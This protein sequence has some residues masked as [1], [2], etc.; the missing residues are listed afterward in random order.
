MILPYN[1]LG[2]DVLTPPGEDP[3]SGSRL[4]QCMTDASQFKNKGCKSDLYLTTAMRRVSMQSP[5][6]PQDGISDR[7][8]MGIDALQVEAKRG[9]LEA[10]DLAVAKAAHVIGRSFLKVTD[11]CL[12]L[13]KV[14]DQ[15]FVPRHSDALG[16]PGILDRDAAELVDLCCPSGREGE[17]LLDLLLDQFAQ[18]LVR[19]LSPM[20]SRLVA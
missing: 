4:G 16:E 5:C 10:V 9:G 11:F 2:G 7:S 18:A 13:E 6:L 20:C 19:D 8:S 1:L 15:V 17:L 12:C 14:W 3:T